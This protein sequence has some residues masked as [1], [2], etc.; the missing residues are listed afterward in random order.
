M[1]PDSTLAIII[2][3]LTIVT[4]REV[5]ARTDNSTHITNTQRDRR[6][7]KILQQQQQQQ[8]VSTP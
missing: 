3:L 5:T 7:N 6:C 8:L 1:R 2:Y 4:S